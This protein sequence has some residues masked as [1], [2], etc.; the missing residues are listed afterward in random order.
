MQKLIE[1]YNRLLSQQ[2]EIYQRD[3]FK[4]FILD[5]R[6]IGIVGPR[7]VGKTTF[8]LE[9]AKKKYLNSDKALYISADDPYFLKKTL[10]DCAEKFIN[11][12]N[13]ELLFLDLK[14]QK[15]YTE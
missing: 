11:E 12:Y 4:E 2:K 5:G 1:E 9:I 15:I 13:G 14:K 7:G 3:I 10:L 8:L 6:I